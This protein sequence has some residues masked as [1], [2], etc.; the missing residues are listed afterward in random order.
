MAIT[1]QGSSRTIF[2]SNS[3]ADRSPGVYR[4]SWSV[5]A[6]AAAVIVVALLAFS[7]HPPSLTL[8]GPAFVVE[9]AQSVADAAG[10][11]ETAEGGAIEKINAAL[12]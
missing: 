1:G 6:V 11:G 5:V 7:R 8:F 3:S 2:S 12:R 9:I 4:K 10:G